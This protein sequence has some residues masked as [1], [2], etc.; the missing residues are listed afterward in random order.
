MVNDSRPTTQANR[1]NRT[2]NHQ[3]VRTRHLLTEEPD[4][5][6]TTGFYRVRDAEHLPGSDNL[7]QLGE[8]QTNPAQ[9]VWGSCAV[10][11]ASALNV[12]V[13]IDSRGKTALFRLYHSGKSFDVR[14][15]TRLNG[16]SA[17]GVLGWTEKVYALGLRKTNQVKDGLTAWGEMNDGNRMEQAIEMFTGRD[18]IHYYEENNPTPA[19]MD[20]ALDWG[21]TVMVATLRQDHPMVVYNHAYRVHHIDP[22]PNGDYV[23][24]MTN[25][26]G[27]DGKQPWGNPNDGVIGLNTQMFKDA[28]F[29]V[30]I[31]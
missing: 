29:Q 10:L 8:L 30:T 9:G 31:G 12:R 3:A 11:A 26:W 23:F 17:F 21:Q 28:Q 14:T 22:L 19:H 15:S 7:I 6:N 2:R 1:P 20:K 24:Y 18:A 5:L 13:R 25:P 16:A 27:Y 4:G